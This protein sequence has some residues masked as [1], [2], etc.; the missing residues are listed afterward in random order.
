MRLK[1]LSYTKLIILMM[2]LYLS[3][4][5]FF[6][7]LLCFSLAAQFDESQLTYY[8]PVEDYDQS[9]T[10]PKD[11]LG[12]QVGKRHVS[13][14]ELLEYLSLIDLQSD[15]ITLDTY[16]LSHEER[17]LVLL[18][19]TGKQNHRNLESI[20]AQHLAIANNPAADHDLADLPAIIYQGYSIHG[21]EASGSN[22]A[23]LTAYY[24]A[25]S[26]SP[27]TER[28]LTE[29][30][31][32]FDPCYNPDGFHRFSTWVNSHRSTVL[33]PDPLSVEF[34]ER[35]PTGR[36]NHYW[37][38]LNRDWLLLAHPE[39]R[40][41]AKIF[42]QW[43]PNVLTDHHEM[44]KNS[45]FFF[46]PGVPERTN[47]LTPQRNQDLTEDISHYHI[48]NLDSIGSDYFTKQRF[49]DYY[50]GKGSTYPDALG[51]VGILFEQAGVE[52]HLQETNNGLLSFP[53][54]I[55]NQVVTSF[56]TWEA[57]VEMRE[58]LL[59]YKQSFFRQRKEDASNEKVNGY[60]LSSEDPYVMR[61]LEDW[62]AH[63]SIE[64]SP[65]RDGQVYVGMDQPQYLL[66]KSMMEPTQVFPDSIFY[67]VSTWT[68]PMAFDLKSIP[69]SDIP[70]IDLAPKQLVSNLP[71][72]NETSGYYTIEWSQ[73]LT[74][75]VLQELLMADQEVEL[76]T[77]AVDEGGQIL[78][79]AGS[80]LVNPTPVAQSILQSAVQEDQIRVRSITKD[81]VSQS[82]TKPLQPKSIGLLIGND[83]NGY[84]AGSIWHTLDVRWGIPVTLLDVNRNHR[85]NFDR[86]DVII[87]PSDIDYI[88]PDYEEK[89]LKWIADGGTLIG[90]KDA[91]EWGREHKLCK[92]SAKTLRG[93]RMTE[94]ESGIANVG[95]AI[96][97]V[98]VDPSSPLSYGYP[99]GEMEVFHRGNVF[100]TQKKGKSPLNYTD[101]PVASGFVSVKNREYLKNASAA[102][103]TQKGK[104]TCIFLQDNP[105][106]RGYWL[107]GG[108]LLGSAIWYG[109]LD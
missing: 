66:L 26:R 101:D 106:F 69:E 84:D 107:Q 43:Y 54:A 37:F 94:R 47:L 59:K 52:G 61:Y 100:Y 12:Y 49:D 104:G 68:L 53:F 73:Y 86:Y 93:K 89:L 81:L 14:D 31:I 1:S 10:T 70:F 85:A 91:I 8:L 71:K 27:F 33:N 28:L 99:D 78:C 17:P 97:N 24:L 46:Q 2:R 20:Q 64:A 19:I 96:F 7:S 88:H 40:G 30:V 83:A 67:D 42:H 74:S 22:A 5:V 80:L 6:G 38:D 65:T 21:D 23:L 82:K 109:D 98:A 9:I 48:R 103:V 25:A 51:C 102:I 39:S 55:R 77:E 92:V 13:H 87:M 41:R 62:F 15:R 29:T 76:I 63:H 50:F 95:G 45:S 35:W 79:N 58:E 75:S 34:Q 3:I 16:A 108:P 60:Y 56:S 36:G 105:C 32:L 90:I 44:G 11:Y 57:T 4:F 18:T 72:F